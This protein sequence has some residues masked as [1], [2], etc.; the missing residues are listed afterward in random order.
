MSDDP[1]E[2]FAKGISE[3]ENNL[4]TI[5]NTNTKV[6]EQPE[7]L[8]PFLR[9]AYAAAKDSDSYALATIIK[10]ILTQRKAFLSITQDSLNRAIEVD[11]D[12]KIK[13]LKKLKRLTALL[14]KFEIY[15]IWDAKRDGS[16]LS[17]GYVCAN[18]SVLMLLGLTNKDSTIQYQELQ[19]YCQNWE[20]PISM[21]I[22]NI[23]GEIRV[24]TEEIRNRIEENRNKL[25]E[26][27][28][29]KKDSRNLI[30]DFSRLEGPKNKFAAP[31][32]PSKIQ[33]CLKLFISD[34]KKLIDSLIENNEFEKL[35][36]LILEYSPLNLKTL[37]GFSEVETDQ[38]RSL[39]HQEFA[40]FSGINQETLAE[41]VTTFIEVDIEG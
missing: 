40:K 29:K 28:I 27:R 24:Q 41:L 8:R 38:L 22:D 2:Y 1:K 6:E 34:E 25:E 31:S 3:F 4:I 20:V 9:G 11:P 32:K 15:Q 16:K 5:Q 19:S 37:F 35:K 7:H 12:N 36:S 26:N 17:G 23:S 39:I 18:R 13:K 14:A 33:I 30:A 21:V 10:G